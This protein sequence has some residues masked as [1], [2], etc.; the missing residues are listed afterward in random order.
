M[1]VTFVLPMLLRAPMGGFRVV[2]TYANQLSRRGHVVTVVHANRATLASVRRRP[3]LAGQIR[4][5]GAVAR[6]CLLT[7]TVRWERVEPAVRLMHRS[8]L[9]DTDVP[10]GDVV[11]A[12]SWQTAEPVQ[13]LHSRKGHKFYLIQHHETWAGPSDAVDATWRFPLRKVVIARWLY[14]LGLDLGVD[15]GMMRLVPNGIDHSTFRVVA[16]V[17][18]RPK[19]VAM[20]YS[21]WA[22]KGAD[23]GIRALELARAHEPGLQAVLFGISHR[24]TSLPG[25]IDYRRD[26]TQDELVKDVYNGSAIYL[27]P[28]LTEGWHLPP[29][30]AMACGCAV[31]STAIPGVRDYAVDGRTALLAPAADPEALGARLVRLLGDER[32]R[33]RLAAEGNRMVKRFTWDAATDALENWMEETIRRRED[34][35]EPGQRLRP[36]P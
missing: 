13:R 15:P 6:D 26:P 10:D 11:V 16:P 20:L 28:S 35:S 29:A 12:T 30:E 25:W 7:P 24:P 36:Q 34:N 33:L 21:E 14:D 9:A 32:L 31:V 3:T 8:A 18:N 2:Y 23:D 22:W 4:G 1:R 17:G 27:C 5:F 19:R